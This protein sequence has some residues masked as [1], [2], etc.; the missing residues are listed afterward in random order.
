VAGQRIL[1]G[2]VLALAVALIA[3]IPTVKAAVPVEVVKT[4][5]DP[6]IR[7]AAQS[8]AQFAVHVSHAASTTTKGSWS[9]EGDRAI[10]RYAVRIPTAVS[11]SFHAAPVHLPT[12]SSL[13]VRSSVTTISY[14]AR[15]LR[16]ADLW[17]RIQPGD[18][19]ELTLD[20]PL[21]ERSTVTFQIVSLQ[22]GYRSLGGGVADHPLY[23]KLRMKDASTGT[24]SCVQNYMCNA[25]PANTPLAQAT[26]GIVVG[27]AYQCTGTLINDVPGDNTP[28][29]LTAR[30]CEAGV[31]G[32]S[33]P[34]AAA[35]VTVYWDATTPCGQT[36]GALYDPGIQTQSG[37]TTMVEQQ[38]AW[39]IRL[40]DSPV[41][42]D[43]QFAGF[44]ASGGVIQGGYT[45]QH[46]LGFDK[47]FTGWF[48]QALASQQSAVLNTTYES[49]FWEVVNQLGNI[50]PGASGSG[51]IDQ[52]NHLV[53]SLTL[54]E[55]S[56]DPSGYGICPVTPPV[57]P[58]G[59]NP[60]AEF[61]SLAAVWSST[62]DTTSTT[63]TTTLK[64]VLDP[65]NT[66]TLVAASM[67]A[68]TLAFTSSILTPD[69]G[70]SARL[71]WTAPQATQCSA[72]GGLPGDGWSGTLPASGSQSVS[73][74][75]AGDV[76]YNL[77]CQLAGGGSVSASVKISWYGSVPYVF[78]NLPRFA[79]WTTRPAQIDWSSN[80]SPCAISGGGLSLSGLP[81]SGSTT[82][83]QSSPGDVT[84]QVSCGSGPTATSGSAT[85]SFVTPSLEFLA[86]G[87]DRQLSAI[88]ALGWDTAADT[89]TPSGGAPNDGWA[90]TSFAPG[91]E[92]F[93]YPRVTTVGT[94]TYTLSCSSGPLTVQQ[95]VVVTFDNNAPYVTASVSPSTTT[96]TASPADYITVNW[97]TNITGCEVN[98]T[99][100]LGSSGSVPIP[101]VA[102][103]FTNNAGQ[104]PTI[105]APQAP[106]TY[107]LSVTCEAVYFPFVTSAPVTVT[108]LP[109]PP[110]T[111][112][113]SITPS[114]VVS[115]GNQNLAVAWS[116]TNASSCTMATSS[117]ELSAAWLLG[118][119]P[120][121]ASGNWSLP[122]E[123]GPGKFTLSVTCQSIDPNQGTA[124]AQAAFNI[125]EPTATL[126]ASPSSLTVGQTFTLNWS[127]DAAGSCTA[128]GPVSLTWSGSLASSGTATVTATGA[129]SL[130]YSLTCGTGLGEAQAQVVVTVAAAPSSS[131]GGSSSS[132][133][134][135]GGGG[136]VDF[137]EIELLA[138]TLVGN[139]L[140]RSRRQRRAR[141]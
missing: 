13:T 37:A 60:V 51:L 44:D 105:I 32:E 42:T 82:A 76:T 80:V 6:L 101:P 3:L 21:S 43:A 134:S 129:G 91:Q 25:T 94:Y 18:T 111:A 92:Q 104:G 26:V 85:E 133:G 38:D 53:G 121:P 98:S 72:T 57:A 2:R 31:L 84:Y 132:G 33:S 108:I 96:F 116:S 20:V 67:P 107:T 41:V 12:G 50:G 117:A 136:A 127:S 30:H 138:A 90:G 75:S 29:V 106:G 118:N 112:T 39:L 113:I 7:A 49:D 17:S 139:A 45:I 61:T 47:Q 69:T 68:A 83:T 71:N 16:K 48:G 141:G 77:A 46:A 87:T 78:V 102:A 23:T 70:Q 24:A 99:P 109:P 22:A 125:V 1:C 34:S 52:N 4:N 122:P 100:L 40:D 63:G 137:L 27:N 120:G 114:S 79:V 135:G 95:S 110:P 74:G 36:L 19:L 11:M 93:F 103:M 56:N 123:S 28:Y 124:T 54:G 58:N 131:G 89:C 64:S 8:P 55:T 119:G 86:N 9:S 130:T 59:S 128:G 88:F 81:S 97:T 15:E 10:W 66:G 115:Y 5:L 35:S 73:E 14:P 126:T 140:R 65:A 62:A